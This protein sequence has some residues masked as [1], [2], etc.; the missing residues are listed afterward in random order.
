[1]KLS[2]PSFVQAK[3]FSGSIQCRHIDSHRCGI[4][5]LLRKTILL[6][7]QTMSSVHLTFIFLSITNRKRSNLSYFLICLERTKFCVAFSNFKLNQCNL[8]DSLHCVCKQTAPLNCTRSYFVVFY[9]CGVL[10]LAD[11]VLNW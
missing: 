11:L 8:I 6:H 10:K 1:M 3:R 5:L 4:V 9:N 7:F 2:K